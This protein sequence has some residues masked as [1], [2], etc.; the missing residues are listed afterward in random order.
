MTALRL[1]QNPEQ[2]LS[3][4]QVGITL[5]GILAGAL[6]GAALAEDL[7]LPLKKISMIAPYATTVSFG[8]V[9][10]IITYFSLVIGELLPKN[11]ALR[12]PEWWAC[13]VAPLLQFVV[14]VA[15][16]VVRV[17]SLSTGVVLRTLGVKQGGE[18]VV[19]EEEVNVM[20]AE[21]T[22][23]GVFH[24]SEGDIVARVL[25]LGDRPIRSMMTPRT[26]VAW[27]RKGTSLAEAL[28][29][30]LEA[31]YSSYPYCENSPDNVV[32]I[33]SLKNTWR[34][35]LEIRAGTAN[36]LE[37][38]LESLVA[39]PLKVPQGMS[40]LEVLEL[41]RR[42][43]K[44]FALVLDEFGGMAGIVTDHDLL[45]AL[46]GYIPD[47]TDGEDSAFTRREDGSYLISGWATLDELV[48]ILRIP[49][50]PPDAGYHT[51]AGLSMDQLGGVP[52]LGQSFLYGGWKFEIIDLDG[53]RVDKVLAIPAP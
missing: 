41:F 46:V 32:G 16:P 25:R 15:S 24:H 33:I 31:G 4:V 19:T 12:N 36:L 47:T 38:D 34:A 27:I 52:R 17:L 42:E 1:L 26:E 49:N 20:I 48:Q 43:R 8:I 51:L 14:V 29:R 50:L 18:T 9:V 45:E 39:E 6:G 28:E 3:A 44:H 21:G 22:K 35:L 2:F 10:G 53:S 40:G 7:A 30:M 37:V 11:I 13:A 23:A 5:I